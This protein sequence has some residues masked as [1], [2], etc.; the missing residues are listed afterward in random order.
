M[1]LESTTSRVAAMRLAPMGVAPVAIYLK[2]VS[3][4]VALSAAFVVG[5]IVLEHL[6]ALPMRSAVREHVRQNL[7][8][9]LAPS[10]AL[11]T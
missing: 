4:V 3:E 7:Q 9:E 5:L 11:I 10:G 2:S 6:F 1:T 8:K